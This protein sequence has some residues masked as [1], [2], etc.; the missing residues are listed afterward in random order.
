MKDCKYQYGFSKLHS[1]EVYDIK[2]RQQKAKKIHAVLNNYYNGETKGLA[3]L[4]MGCSTGIVSNYLSKSFASVTGIDIDKSAIDYAVNTAQAENIKFFLRDALNTGFADESFD[5]VICAHIYEHVSDP[6]RLLSEIKRVL[7]LGGVCYFA[8]ENRLNLLE[9]HYKLPFLSVIPKS[10]AHFYLRI[11]RKGKFYYEN[12]LTYW[13]LKRLVSQF[14]FGIID[15][16]LLVIN[17]PEKYSAI[18]MIKPNSIKQKLSRKI[19]KLAYW[20]CPTYIWL[21]RK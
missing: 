8:A 6:Y 3:V 14:N 10:L 19:I 18:E 7:K 13:G 5:I 12:L 20:L 4:D 1:K 16:T 2:S 11:I 17:E 15:Y 9:A 21:L